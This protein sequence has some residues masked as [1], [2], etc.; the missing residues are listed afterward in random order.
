MFEDEVFFLNVPPIFKGYVLGTSLAM[1]CVFVYVCMRER[2]RVWGCIF[3]RSGFVKQEDASEMLMY[4]PL[5][6]NLIIT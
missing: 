4:L 5:D 3:E 2:E 6:R 1:F